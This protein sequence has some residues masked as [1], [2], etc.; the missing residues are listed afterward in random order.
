[1]GESC[2]KQ[3]E[4]KQVIIFAKVPVIGKVK[5][6]LGR[7]IGMELAYDVYKAILKTQIEILERSGMP[8][9][10]CYT[11]E[12]V[13][14]LV[15]I[16]GDTC[17]LMEQS[18]GNLGNRMKRAFEACFSSGASEI[19]LM[20]S[21]IP[22]MTPEIIKES[23][24]CLNDTGV[25]IGATEDGGYYLVGFKREI[26]NGDIFKDIHWGTS[27]VY[28][29]TVDKFIKNN[30]LYENISLLYD[31]DTQEDLLRYVDENNTSLGQELKEVLKL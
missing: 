26:F 11:G 18:E 31:I 15:D 13:D 8:F 29:E 10:V 1:M 2:G 30:I 12:P 23:F 6:R 3:F 21:D 27:T 9:L 19:I 4:D 28:R 25:V 24:Q 16:I 5:T 7:E 14:H 22:S 17:S 20:G